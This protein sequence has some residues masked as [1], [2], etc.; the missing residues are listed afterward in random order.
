MFININVG[1]SALF[2][3]F[4]PFSLS[5]CF[6]PSLP[7]LKAISLYTENRTDS[8]INCHDPLFAIFSRNNQTTKHQLHIGTLNI[9][10]T[11][12]IFQSPF[13]RS[14]S[15]SDLTACIQCVCVSVFFCFFFCWVPFRYWTCDLFCDYFAFFCVCV[16]RMEATCRH[17]YRFI[18]EKETTFFKSMKTVERCSIEITSLCLFEAANVFFLCSQMSTCGMCIFL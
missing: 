7:Y 8:M 6:S 14:I 11:C 15:L 4:L 3:F 12:Q 18:R 16:H 9:L 2:P 17:F 13:C 1:L 10:C 5:H